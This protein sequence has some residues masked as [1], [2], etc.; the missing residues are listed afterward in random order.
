MNVLAENELQHEQ[1]KLHY[2]ENCYSAK[3]EKKKPSNDI[4]F[5]QNM[6]TRNK[7]QNAK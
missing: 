4:L 2:K 6:I 1:K 7:M 5:S 3:R